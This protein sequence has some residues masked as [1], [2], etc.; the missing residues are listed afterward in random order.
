MSRLHRLA[1]DESFVFVHIDVLA[2]QTGV[3]R[4]TQ[5]NP[6]WR[7]WKLRNGVV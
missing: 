4:F 7:Y 2:A 1:K 6:N 5:D 3:S